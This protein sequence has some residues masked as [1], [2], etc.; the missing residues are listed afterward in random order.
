M[1]ITQAGKTR[2][3][4]D[5]LKNVMFYGQSGSLYEVLAEIN[6]FESEGYPS[7]LSPFVTQARMELFKQKIEDYLGI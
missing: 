3:V 5:Y 7:D 4:A 1:G 2:S 6:T